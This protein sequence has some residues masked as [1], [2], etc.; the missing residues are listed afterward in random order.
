MDPDN[1]PRINRFW[2]IKK[3]IIIGTATK[4]PARAISG[5]KIGTEVAPLPGLIAGVEKNSAPNPTGSV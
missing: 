1:I 2:E 5:F 3:T 4:I